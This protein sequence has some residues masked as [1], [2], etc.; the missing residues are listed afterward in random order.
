MIYR[1]NPVYWGRAAAGIMFF[2][3]NEVL[4]LLRSAWVEE[5]YT[6][7]IPGGSV[8]GE[9][10]YE[11]TITSP[12]YDETLFWEGACTETEEELGFIPA[13]DSADIK[14]RVVFKDESF[15]FV[16]YI[17]EVSSGQ[18]KAFNDSITLNAENVDWGWFSL[19]S[20]PSPLH[21]GVEYVFE[22]NYD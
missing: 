18:R 6:W 17:V 16:T 5:P 21:P 7:G 8:I 19:D 9:D 1:R 20:L 15:I 14:N 4:L 10:Y 22:R 11:T 13:I 2:C 12:Q 3:G